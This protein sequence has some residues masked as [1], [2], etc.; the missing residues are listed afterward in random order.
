[1]NKKVIYM[2]IV[3]LLFIAVSP[4]SKCAIVS[5]NDLTAEPSSTVTEI[6]IV[7]KDGVNVGASTI[8][9][10]YD[11][12]VVTVSEVMDG[13]FDNTYSNIDNTNG[14][15]NISTFQLQS[16]GLNGTVIIAN[17]SFIAGRAGS[18]T[19]HLEATLKDATIESKDIPHQVKD[20][21]FAVIGTSADGNITPIPAKTSITTPTVA[22]TKV[23]SNI[24]ATP[25]VAPTKITSNVSAT[26]TA[27]P[28]KVTSEVS[29]TPTPTPTK[30]TSE[31]SATPTPTPTKVTIGFEI[32]FA[33]IELIMM[34]FALIYY[35]NR[36]K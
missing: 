8:S 19:L 24:S 6:P 34:A 18:C 2:K 11:P 21:T 4:V 30:V 15:T 1:M 36:K 32:V 10:V 31:V 13:D 17:L 16:A 33:I 12:M 29:A 7:I 25:T 26:P 22:P 3:L 14:R 20:G 9:L 5:I 27:T 28:T 35:K 23:T